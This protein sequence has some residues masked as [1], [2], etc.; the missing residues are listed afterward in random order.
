MQVLAPSLL[1]SQGLVHSLVVVACCSDYSSNHNS[2]CSDYLGYL[3]I[4]NLHSDFDSSICSDM[5]CPHIALAVIDSADSHIGPN[6][7]SSALTDTPWYCAVHRKI[8]KFPMDY[9]EWHLLY[10]VASVAV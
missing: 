2:D 6:L 3:T 9:S 10:P 5:H 8:H 4:S 1:S 7:L